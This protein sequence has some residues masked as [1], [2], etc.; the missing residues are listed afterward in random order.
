MK[1][2]LLKNIVSVF[3]LREDID[4]KKDK[5]LCKIVYLK[6]FGRSKNVTNKPGKTMILLCTFACTLEL[7]F[8]EPLTNSRLFIFIIDRLFGRTDATLRYG[9]YH[10][11]GQVKTV[12]IKRRRSI[13]YRIK[14]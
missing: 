12:E 13:E 10:S 11:L 5:Y 3:T 6:L 14:G 9:A 4:T 8:Q 7:A 2:N 1:C